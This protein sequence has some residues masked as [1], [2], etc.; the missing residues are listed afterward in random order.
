MF[1]FVNN[2]SYLIFYNDLFSNIII[3]VDERHRNKFKQRLQTF[4]SIQI[5]I[6][7]NLFFICYI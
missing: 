7:K 5:K 4:F 6:L 1:N 2:L 3:I